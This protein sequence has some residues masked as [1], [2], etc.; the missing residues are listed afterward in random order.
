MKPGEKKYQVITTSEKYKHHLAHE[1][2]SLSIPPPVPENKDTLD[3]KEDPSQKKKKEKTISTFPVKRREEPD[4]PFAQYLMTF[5]EELQTIEILKGNS[6]LSPSHWTVRDAKE[7][8][9][10]L[11]TWKML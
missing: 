9:T 5:D 7:Q 2:L 4:T 3:Q 10:R 1:S 11:R 6:P 8:N